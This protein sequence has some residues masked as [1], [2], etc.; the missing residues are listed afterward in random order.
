MIQK[1]A[2][3]ILKLTQ[4]KKNLITSLKLW[5]ILWGFP[6]CVPRHKRLRFDPRIGN[7]P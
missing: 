6:G 7:I 3:G 2:F 4:K 5:S 1:E